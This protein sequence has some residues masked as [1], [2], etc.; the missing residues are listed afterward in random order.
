MPTRNSQ[1]PRPLSLTVLLLLLLAACAACGVKGATGSANGPGK[2][3]LS[4]LPPATLALT[5][6]S[7]KIW[8]SAMPTHYGIHSP[9]P[10]EQYGFKRDECMA[11]LCA[12]IAKEH[13][14]RTEQVSRSLGKN[15]THMDAAVYFPFPLLDCAPPP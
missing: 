13:G 15:R 6:S 12:D 3:Q 5:P 11:A 8:R 7:P 9:T 4:W 14:V 1:Q 10:S 2:G